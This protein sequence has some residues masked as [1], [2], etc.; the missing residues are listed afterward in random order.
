MKFHKVASGECQLLHVHTAGGREPL[1][2]S[3]GSPPCRLTVRSISKCDDSRP[4]LFT[5]VF[6]LAILCL[7]VAVQRLRLHQAWWRRWV[8]TGKEL[9]VRL[10]HETICHLSLDC[11]EHQPSIKDLVFH[12]TLLHLKVSF[13]MRL[14][15]MKRL[16]HMIIWSY[17]I[18]YDHV[19]WQ[20]SNIW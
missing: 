17:V 12:L 13:M 10:L 4:H 9:G 3:G 19:L 8:P 7:H 20:I 11:L 15:H 18:S 1:S 2:W 14:H 16:H 6:P 5:L